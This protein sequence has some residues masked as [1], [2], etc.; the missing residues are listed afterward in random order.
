M[1][2]TFPQIS[3]NT[4]RNQCL[5]RPQFR[6]VVLILKKC[7]PYTLTND[8]L[9]V[10]VLAKGQETARLIRLLQHLLDKSSK[11][12]INYKRL[13]YMTTI[14]LIWTYGVEFQGSPKRSNSCHIQYEILP[15]ILYALYFVTN[16]L[17]YNV[18]F[19]TDQDRIRYLIILDLIVRNSDFISYYFECTIQY[20]LDD[21]LCISKLREG[22]E[23]F[24][25]K[26]YYEV[27]N[28][29]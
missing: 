9:G 21:K 3:P 15:K 16:K 5:S 25:N 4:W 2:N 10:L 13:I 23:M 20:F 19:V 28:H 26:I 8:Q 12:S 18:P 14:R 7:S 6:S 17:S 22:M 24:V 29:F 1:I 27:V 11:S